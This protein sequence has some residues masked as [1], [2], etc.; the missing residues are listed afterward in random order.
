MLILII[1]HAEA[2]VSSI[3]DEKRTLSARGR[4]DAES[5]GQLIDSAGIQPDLIEHSPLLRAQQ[6]A[7]IIAN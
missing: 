4:K 7:A 2:D 5:L 6:T 3:S 1:R